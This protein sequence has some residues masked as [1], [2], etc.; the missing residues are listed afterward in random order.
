MFIKERK[1]TR[2]KKVFLIG[3][4]LDKS[5]YQHIK[6]LKYSS[7]VIIIQTSI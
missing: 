4:K 7:N 3:T 1:F 5:K 2:F 6:Q